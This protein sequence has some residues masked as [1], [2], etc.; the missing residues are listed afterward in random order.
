MERKKIKCV[1]F[2]FDKD[3]DGYLEKKEFCLVLKKMGLM[4]INEIESEEIFNNI[5][6]DGNGMIIFDEF[7]DY[8]IENIL[9]DEKFVLCKVFV[10]VDKKQRGVVN[11]KEFL[12]FVRNRNIFVIFEKVLFMFDKLCGENEKEEF[13]Y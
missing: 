7:Y 1:F 12:E 3:G 9:C 6:K 2:D 5:D 11:F 10:E 4:N 13:I 8:F